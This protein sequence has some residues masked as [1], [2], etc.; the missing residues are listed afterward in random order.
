[1]IEGERDVAHGADGD[2]VINDD[3]P[4]LVKLI[5]CIFDVFISLLLL[6]QRD[7]FLIAYSFS[8]NGY[9]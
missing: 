5:K 3:H 4:F 6:L 7:C 9:L 1:M 8:K 2:C